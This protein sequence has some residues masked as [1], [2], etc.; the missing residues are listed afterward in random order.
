MLPV[1][2]LLIHSF[3]CAGTTTCKPH[4]VCLARQ[5]KLLL[6]LQDEIP[7]YESTER[8]FWQCRALV[9]LFAGSACCSGAA[10]SSTFSADF[11]PPR[12]ECIVHPLS[13]SFCILSPGLLLPVS[14][15]YLFLSLELGPLVLFH[16]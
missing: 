2:V 9:L 7:L 12:S 15:I 5:M 3:I 4:P 1:Q 10:F 14:M 16:L 6:P 13:S 11:D 8:S